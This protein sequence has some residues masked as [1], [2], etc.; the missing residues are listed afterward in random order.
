[1][2]SSTAPNQLWVTEL[3]FVPPWAGV[4]HVCFIVDAYSRT[5]VDWPVATHMKT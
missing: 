5:I 1:M 4:A 2:F 3:T